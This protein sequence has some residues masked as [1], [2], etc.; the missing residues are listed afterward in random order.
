MAWIN[1]RIQRPA[2]GFDCIE[3]AFLPFFGSIK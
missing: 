1:R 2:L 3:H